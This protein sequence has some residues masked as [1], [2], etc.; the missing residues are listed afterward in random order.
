[1]NLRRRDQRPLLDSVEE[2]QARFDLKL[3]SR[4]VR[5]LVENA[6]RASEGGGKVEVLVRESEASV[7]IE[8][9]DHGPG[10]PP[11]NLR[12][13]FEPYFSTSTGGTGLGLPI[14]REAVEQH[15]G[16]VSASNRDQGLRVA[17]ELPVGPG[18]LLG[19]I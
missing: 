9:L 13:I 10:V 8:V 14:V 17:I 3:L 16:E 19:D 12:R 2:F 7:S 15:G 1:M 11:E 4:A 5:N 18:T 6:V